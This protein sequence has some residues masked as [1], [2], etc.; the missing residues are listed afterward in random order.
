MS[1]DVA[2]GAVPGEV[3]ECVLNVDLIAGLFDFILF[4]SLLLF[5]CIHF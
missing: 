3:W 2:E 4:V 5:P 1:I